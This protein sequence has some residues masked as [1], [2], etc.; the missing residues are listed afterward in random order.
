MRSVPV[1]LTRKEVQHLPVR[2]LN[3]EAAQ[4]DR[5]PASLMER[6]LPP[7]VSSFSP[8][9]LSSVRA[10]RELRRLLLKGL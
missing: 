10:L 1:P 8:N 9:A 2:L 7:H 3:V 4:S 5:A 6:L